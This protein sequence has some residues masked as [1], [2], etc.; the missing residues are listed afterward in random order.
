MPDIN[1]FVTIEETNLAENITDARRVISTLDLDDEIQHTTYTLLRK[2][3][4]QNELR[5]GQLI[6]SRLHEVTE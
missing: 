4:D 2:F 6:A 3:T 5:L 1:I